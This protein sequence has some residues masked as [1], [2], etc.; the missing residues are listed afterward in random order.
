V[1]RRD[2]IH[3]VAAL[4]QAA[5]QA[6]QRIRTGEQ[7]RLHAALAAQVDEFLRVADEL[8]KVSEDEVITLEAA[9]DWG[10]P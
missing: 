7:V 5:A 1:T 4:G 9:R 10:E 8:A 6:A 2:R 3:A